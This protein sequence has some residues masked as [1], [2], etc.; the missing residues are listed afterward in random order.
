MNFGDGGGETGGTVSVR[1]VV[2][3]LKHSIYMICCGGCL[4]GGKMVG[5]VGE[6]CSQICKSSEM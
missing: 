5:L 3:A 6:L 4:C 2:S 1:E